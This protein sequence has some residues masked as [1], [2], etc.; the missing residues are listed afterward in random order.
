[1]SQRVEVDGSE[2]LSGEESQREGAEWRE[3]V[4]AAE[5]ERVRA[6]EKESE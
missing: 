6:D 2:K 1:M 4:R 3:T 5:S